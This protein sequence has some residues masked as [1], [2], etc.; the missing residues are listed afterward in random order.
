[1]MP[2]FICVF[3]VAAFVQFFVSY[4]RSMVAH[5]ITVAL[6]DN[7]RE[8][9]GMQSQS[10]GANDFDRF[11]QLLR[12]CPDLAEG[13][14]EVR[15]VGAYYSGLSM[16]SSAFRSMVPAVAAWA[17]RER[18]NCS[19]FVAVILDQRIAQSRDLCLQQVS[20]SL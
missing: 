8:F 10:V 15:A 18:Q 20:A 3:S 5:S 9:A 6:S 16:L 11:R 17:E 4:C 2:A 19:Y 14:K 13:K 12:L 1:M 7:L